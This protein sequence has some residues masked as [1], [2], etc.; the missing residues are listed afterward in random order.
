MRWRSIQYNLTAKRRA[1]ATF[2]VPL[3][4][5]I[6]N[7]RYRRPNSGSPRAAVSRFH[8]QPTQQQAVALLADRS[9]AL[10]PSA[11]MFARI[12]PQVTHQLAAVREAVPPAPA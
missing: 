12:Q 7:R 3:A 1:T 2:A 11:R 10:L 4:R 6:F 8:Q 5:R 9:Q